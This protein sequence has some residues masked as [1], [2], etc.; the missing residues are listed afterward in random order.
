MFLFAVAAT[1]AVAGADVDRVPEDFPTVQE[2]VD[3]G[4]ASVIR[5]GAGRWAGAVVDR[6]V[7][8]V[9]VDGAVFDRGV[10]A[11]RL[12]PALHLLPG[13]SGTTVEDLVVDCHSQVDAGVFSTVR[14]GG[15]ATDVVVRGNRFEGCVQGVTVAGRD[16]APVDA[17]WWVEGNT[18]AGLSAAPLRGGTGGVLGVVAMNV[19]LVDVVDNRF[20]GW[21]DEVERFRSA[22]TALVGCERC[23]VVANG[24]GVVGGA[25]HAAVV[26]E[27]S[28]AVV[29]DGN[30]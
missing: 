4:E 26:D 3:H 20:E 30:E 29:V 18:F 27:G 17:L 24:F 21:A 5:V 16:E 1:S 9:G 19:A 7:R 22:E 11:G 10:V 12:T 8:I 25:T 14:R 15:V 28:R 23:S 6:P 13:A 2:A